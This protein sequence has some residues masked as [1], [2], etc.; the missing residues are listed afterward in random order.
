M[1]DISVTRKKKNLN[2]KAILIKVFTIN[3]IINCGLLAPSYITYPEIYT[4][5]L[6]L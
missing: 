2:T 6:L 4:T 3:G 5:C 1:D